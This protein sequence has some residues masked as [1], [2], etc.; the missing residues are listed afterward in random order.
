MIVMKFGGSS[1][2]NRP[3]IEKV[4]AIVRS[5]A[6]RGPLV[7]SSAHKGITDA[8]VG[9]ARDA[10]RGVLAPER[11]IDR[12]AAIAGDLGCDAG[13]LAPFF[14]EIADLLRGISLVRELSPRSLD[15]IASFGERMSV[16][17]LADFFTRSGL[18]AQA[19]DVWDLGFV[20]DA[21]FGA[22]RPLPGYEAAMRRLVAERVP[23]G[24]VP[25]VTGFVGRTEA[26]EITT[27]GRNGSDLTATLVGAALGAAEVEIWSDTDGV[28]TADPSVVPAARSIPAMRFEE[29]AELAYF[30]SRVLHPSTLLPT[31]EKGIPVRVLNT[32]RPDHPGTVI[33]DGARDERGSAAT[34]IAYKEGQVV[35][36]ITS[37][38]M[39]GEAGFLARTFEV[40]GRHKV[41]VDMVATSEISVAFTTDRR[42]PLERALAELGALGECRVEDG[43][44]LL[45]VVGRHLAER[46]GLGAAILQA[47]ADAAVNVEMVSYGMK[48]ISL[49]MLISDRDVGKAVNVLHPRLFEGA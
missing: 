41:V 24:V 11:V 47:I 17:V 40:L 9:A 35:A 45:V 10:A 21:S 37:T 1:V 29:A 48:S 18:A 22:A 39:F 36:T 25:V 23:A 28:M 38:R 16:R 4:L 5:R 43:K 27:V 13:L 32:N 6:A 49:T 26:G 2:A 31:M 34:C 19:F 33:H 30:G 14:A 42:E 3:Q 8:L 46:A 44:T 12:Q 7:I 20:T 15:Y